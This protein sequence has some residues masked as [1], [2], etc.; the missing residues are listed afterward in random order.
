MMYCSYLSVRQNEIFF[1]WQKNKK[2]R[3]RLFYFYLLDY[4][5][6][7]TLI[8]ENQKKQKKNKLQVSENAKQ[9][10]TNF[11]FKNVAFKKQ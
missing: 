4:I 9:D 3:I 8:L 2:I 7:R 11:F 5:T 10:V 6:R 1:C